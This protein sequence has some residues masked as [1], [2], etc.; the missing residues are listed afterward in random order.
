MT[1]VGF[2]AEVNDFSFLRTVETSPEPTHL[3]AL[4][5]PDAFSDRTESPGHVT[6][7]ENLPSVVVKIAWSCSFTSPHTLMTCAYL[8]GGTFFLISIYTLG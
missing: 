8:S 3:H 7:R 2:L 5:L 1:E 6:G 4:R